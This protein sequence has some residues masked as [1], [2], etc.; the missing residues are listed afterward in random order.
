VKSGIYRLYFLA[1]HIALALVLLKSDFLEK[2]DRKYDFGFT[3]NE[4]TDHYHRMLTY[5]SRMDSN[6]P[7]GSVIFIGDSLTQG[8]PVSAVA[9]PS[10]NYGIGSDTTLGVLKRIPEYLSI[11][12]SAAVVVAAGINDMRRRSNEEIISNMGEISEAVPDSIPLIFSA[13]LPIDEQQKGPEREGWN[14]RIDSLN[15][16][17]SVFVEDEDNR[18]F[19]DAGDDLI[20]SERNLADQFHIGDGV[21]LSSEGNSI[22]IEHLKDTL[23]SSI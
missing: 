20:D 11:N 9:V 23:R 22:W 3:Q 21:H 6:V 15:E 13:V 5:H 7:E 2:V 12:E 4:I 16:Q 1:I 8:L 19:V 18:Y 17:L 14:Q 10:V